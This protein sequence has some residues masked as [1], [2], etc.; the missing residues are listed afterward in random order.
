MPQTFQEFNSTLKSVD[1][2]DLQRAVEVASTPTQEYLEKNFKIKDKDGNL[3]FMSPLKTPQVKLL[4]LYQWC[5]DNDLPTRI[6]VLKARKTGISTLI[7][8]VMLKETLERGIDSI[9]IAHD[10]STAE[11]IFGITHRFWNNYPLSKPEAGVPS[12]H[13]LK[14]KDQEGLM[15]VET[16][17]NAQAGTGMTPQFIH[18]S[19]VAKWEKGTET[20]VALFQSIGESRE[21]SV[22][23]ES[24]AQGFDGLFYPYWDNAEKYC[25]LRWS[26]KEGEPAPDIEILDYE[27]WNGY[28]PFFISWFEDPEYVMNFRNPE[29]RSHFSTTLDDYEKEL[30]KRYQLSYEQLLWRRWTLKNKCQ[31][32]IKIFRQEYPSTPEEAFVTTGRPY[33]DHDKLDLM[34]LEDGRQGYL[35]QIERWEK[36]IKFEESKGDF[37][38]IYRDPEPTHRYVIG[39]DVAEGTLDLDKSKDPDQSVAIVLDLDNGGEQVAV[40]K[41]YIGE[42]ELA[43]RIAMLGQYYNV[44]YIVPE[45]MGYGQ[46]VAIYLGK[47]YPREMLYH[48]TDFLSD[49]P[50]RSRQVGWR[51]TISTRPIMLGDMKQGVADRAIIVHDRDTLKELKRLEWTNKGRIEAGS[52]HDDH[53]FALAL[54]IQGLKS[55]PINIHQQGH[56]GGRQHLP[57]HLRKLYDSRRSSNDAEQ[58]ETTGY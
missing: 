50:K 13:R 3:R 29:Q 5:K 48:R 40:I 19:E 10:K 33:L 42:E 38:T 28:I 46:H 58:D 6:I 18:G 7:E 41:G 45:V 34:P 12:K 22:I 36:T 47:K 55:Y 14:F 1:K 16:A 23:M 35:Y 54:A 51:T 57:E 32:D 27:N 15:V 30:V 25:R 31:N 4:K 20:A 8:A 56:Y 39:I 24:T 2:D 44:A 17:G 26:N 52:G 53:C 21:T 9:V 43:E 37:L 11:Y 49:R